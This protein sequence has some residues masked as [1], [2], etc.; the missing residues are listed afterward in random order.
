MA[1]SGQCVRS[2]VDSDGGLRAE[3]EGISEEAECPD[4]L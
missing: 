4:S 3:P 1:L 2:P